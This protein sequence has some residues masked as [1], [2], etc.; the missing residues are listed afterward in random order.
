MTDELADIILRDPSEN[1]IWVE[2]K[3]QGMVTMRQDGILKVL[4]GITS[5]E[6]VMHTTE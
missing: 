5:V 4:K 1:D 2:A 6:E 3:R